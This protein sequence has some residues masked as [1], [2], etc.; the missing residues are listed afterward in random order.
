AESK[1]KSTVSWTHNALQSHMREANV[2]DY[3]LTTG[4]NVIE[5]TKVRCWRVLLE[6][7]MARDFVRIYKTRQILVIIH[8][9]L[10]TLIQS[11]I[12]SEKTTESFFLRNAEL[13]RE[14]EK[15]EE[16]YIHREI[17]VKR[18][19]DE[20][21]RMKKEYDEIKKKERMYIEKIEAGKQR[22]NML[23][24]KII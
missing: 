11:F 12:S 18:V 17:E 21:E 23:I 3:V 2:R 9:T 15:K 1:L 4:E 24:K 5:S 6:R 14:C 13:V 16:A 8:K 20:M 19:Y 10:S 22:E 7:I